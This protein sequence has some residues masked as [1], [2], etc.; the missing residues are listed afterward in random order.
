M[1]PSKRRYGPIV[2][3]SEYERRFLAA[4]RQDAQAWLGREAILIDDVAVEGDELVMRFR[5]RSRPNCRFGFRCPNAFGVEANLEHPENDAGNLTM[6]IDEDIQGYPAT[7][8]C[9]E[10]ETFW[11]LAWGAEPERGTVVPIGDNVRQWIPPDG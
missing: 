4:L 10:G 6:S 1:P 5:H 9:K 8:D 11:F 3:R 2:E 7:V